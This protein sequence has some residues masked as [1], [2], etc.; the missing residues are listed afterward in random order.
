MTRRLLALAALA[1]IPLAAQPSGAGFTAASTSAPS[2][3]TT[4]ADFNT[5]AVS[6]A[7]PGSPRTGTVALSATASSDRGIAKVTFQ[8]APAGGSTWTDACTATAAPYTCDWSTA[9]VEGT[10]DLRAVARDTAGYER[11][12]VTRHAR[13]R[14]RRRPP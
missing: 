8:C 1:V 12:A 7:D 5:V 13:R 6:F 11:T 14:Q 9:G 3:F 10:F 4:A 2:T